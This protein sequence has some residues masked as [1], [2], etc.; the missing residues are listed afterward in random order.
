MAKLQ[1]KNRQRN[2]CLALCPVENNHR[3]H[4]SPP[5]PSTHLSTPRYSTI[6]WGGGGGEGTFFCP[7]FRGSEAECLSLP[8]PNWQDRFSSNA[9][10][11][12]ARGWNSSAHRGQ[13]SSFF[14]ITSSDTAIP[15]YS[16]TRGRY[17]CKQR[18]YLPFFNELRVHKSFCSI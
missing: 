12:Q 10:S 1:K 4:P 15:L 11:S 6:P 9:D 13:T 14:W 7:R 8:P 18:D 5:P 17:S 16:E 2:H 3:S